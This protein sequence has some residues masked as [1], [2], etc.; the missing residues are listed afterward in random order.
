MSRAAMKQ[1]HDTPVPAPWRVV[2]M[3]DG[4]ANIYG[5]GVHRLEFVACTGL[6]DAARA[7]AHQIVRVVNAAARAGE[8]TNV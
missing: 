7:H 8:D 2:T 5:T 3:S 1:V 6:G 4:S